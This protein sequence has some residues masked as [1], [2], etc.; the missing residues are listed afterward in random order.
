M[1]VQSPTDGERPVAK[2]SDKDRSERQGAPAKAGYPRLH[3]RHGERPYVQ[4]RQDG[5]PESEGDEG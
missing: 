1:E 4:G 2:H 5:V 3:P